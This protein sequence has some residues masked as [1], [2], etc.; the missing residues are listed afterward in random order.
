MFVLCGKAVQWG[1]Q[2]VQQS[3]DSH[4]PIGRHYKWPT[5][6][7][8]ANGLPSF[9]NELFSGPYDYTDVIAP[10]YRDLF[11]GNY[12][13][14]SEGNDY[15]EFRAL[16]A[17]VYESPKLFKHFS[18]G[19][20]DAL[21]ISQI[22]QFIGSLVERYVHEFDTTDYSVA[23][24]TDIFTPLENGVF[25]ESLPVEVHIP[26]LF[27]F[28]DKDVLSLSERVAIERMSDAFQIARAPKVA[29]A[30]GVHPSVVSAAT[31]CLVLRGYQLSHE[32]LRQLSE[33]CESTD[34]YPIS[35]IDS[36]FAALRIV[37]GHD[38]GYAQLLL[39]PIGWA[40]NYRTVLPT[41]EGTSV[42]SYP[43]RLEH[44]GWLRENIPVVTSGGNEH[45]I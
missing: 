12:N 6:G 35:Q 14:K 24:L 28:F 3:R 21:T 18:G 16:I 10:L 1:L 32:S 2:R 41:V 13:Y 7:K 27:L 43:A 15:P 34:A 17:H 8:H 38:T 23:K 29:Y 31:H 26:I 30:P 40:T 22:L 36:F 5:L 44:F 9:S 19:Y 37:T 11:E 25:F 4:Q 20:P 39:S 42:R 45:G 33:A